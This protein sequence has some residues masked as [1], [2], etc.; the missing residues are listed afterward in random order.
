MEPAGVPGRLSRSRGPPMAMTPEHPPEAAPR[1][2]LHG[3]PRPFGVGPLEPDPSRPSSARRPLSCPRLVSEWRWNQ[4]SVARLHL[5]RPCRVVP[6]TDEEARLCGLARV[7][8]GPRRR[9]V[10][11]FYVGDL[12]TGLAARA[13]GRVAPRT[14][15]PALAALPCYGLQPLPRYLPGAPL[16]PHTGPPP[17]EPGRAGR[18]GAWNSVRWWRRTWRHRRRGSTL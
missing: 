13:A 7:T 18:L 15:Y 3:G 6:S 2:A 10:K 5:S 1:P 8:D 11:A 4:G 9:L 16:S 17:V 12:S 14:T